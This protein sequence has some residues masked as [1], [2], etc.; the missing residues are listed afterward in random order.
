MQDPSVR[1]YYQQVAYEARLSKEQVRLL[2][3]TK[4]IEHANILLVCCVLHEIIVF[5][6]LFFSKL[7]PF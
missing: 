2:R 5:V 3:F 6:D 1:T 7:Y 4:L